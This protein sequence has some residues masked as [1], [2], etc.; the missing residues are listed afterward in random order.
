VN[1]HFLGELVSGELLGV[2]AAHFHHLNETLVHHS[3]KMTSIWMVLIKVCESIAYPVLGKRHDYSAG[4]P[5][6]D[7]AVASTQ[8]QEHPG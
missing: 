3:H 1:W 5:V 8:P 2:T 6:A 4:Q 7:L